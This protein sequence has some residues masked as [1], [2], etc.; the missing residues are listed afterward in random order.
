MNE[1]TDIT[2]QNLQKQKNK[3]FN[4]NN[5]CDVNVFVPLVFLL[6]RFL[7]SFVCCFYKKLLVISFKFMNN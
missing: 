2:K 6:F 4:N 7:K 5:L 1:S 3:R